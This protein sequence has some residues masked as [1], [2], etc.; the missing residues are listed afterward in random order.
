V[1]ALHAIGLPLTQ[2]AQQLG[3][4]WRTARNFAYAETFPERASIKPRASQI[5]RYATYLEQRWAAGCTNASQLWRE[6]QAQGYTGTRKQVARWAQHQRTEPAPTTPTKY[7]Q[8]TQRTESGSY[9]VSRLPSPRE[10][11]WTLLRV[12][13]QLEVADKVV[14][15]H[16]HQD[17]MM[18]SAH[19]LAQSFQ[20][21][22]R[23]RQADQLDAWL[24][25]CGNAEA[26]ELQNFA[27]SLRREESAIAA[28]LSEPWST[29]PVEGQ[30]TRLKSIKRQ[31]CGRANFDLLRRRVL[32]T[33]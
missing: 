33:A 18:A 25:R 5:D 11:V 27:A 6:I 31:M 3:M 28:A 13:E 20:T 26:V 29:G 9:T 8:P 14:L 15:E 21:M 19:D 23:Q 10:L 12:P 30:I 7:G 2:I 4:S 16:L 24:H 32:Q 17:E 22:V 1:R